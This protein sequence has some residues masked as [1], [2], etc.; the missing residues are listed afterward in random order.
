M[1]KRF[2]VLSPRPGKDDKTF[3]HRVGTAWEGDKGIS[4]T[5][6]SLPLPGS[7]GKVRVSLFE[8]REKDASNTAAKPQRRAELD[9]EIPFK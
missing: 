9:D 6:D 2:D 5:F 3:W 8:P 4:I 1:T 7:D